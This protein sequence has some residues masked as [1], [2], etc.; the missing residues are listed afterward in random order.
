[1]LCF[2]MQ[3]AGVYDL[4]DEEDEDASSDEFSEVTTEDEDVPMD[5]EEE[6]AEGLLLL[7]GPSEKGKEP[8]ASEADVP[9]PVVDEMEGCFMQG[10]EVVLYGPASCYALTRI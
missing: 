10:D 8:A 2:M 1:M 6:A 4:P 7:E 5:E 3:E 9:P